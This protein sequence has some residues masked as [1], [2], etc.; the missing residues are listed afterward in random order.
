MYRFPLPASGLDVRSCVTSGQVFRWS[1][2]DSGV[3]SGIDGDAFYR[4]EDGFVESN[5]PASSF[6]RLFR[7][8]VDAAALFARLVAAGPELEPYLA[9][10]SGY[11]L[12]RPSDPVESF[13]SFLCTPNN[14]IKRITAM[15]ETLGEQG[16]AL[17]VGKW[18]RF[19]DLDAIASLDEA[20][21]RSRGFGYRGA[22]IPVIARELL[23]RGSRS[24]L[25]KLASASYEEA[26]AEL[27][28]FKGIGPK[29]ADCIALFALD[30]TEAVPVDTHV[31]KAVTGLYFPEWRSGAITD[32]RYKAAGDFL[33]ARFGKDA[34]WAQQ[35]LFYDYQLHWRSRR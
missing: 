35:F 4:I 26:H 1:I 22:T 15:V 3:W 24:Y 29:L 32:V 17:L 7:L 2:D 18:R 16:P 10:L 30:H 23:A 20:Y 27:V 21:L 12:M 5:Q 11:R 6:E 25:S 14:H 28:S 8:D 33:R 13:F 9:S 19:P 34:G 31:W